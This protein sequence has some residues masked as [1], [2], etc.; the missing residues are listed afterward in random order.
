MFQYLVVT[1]TLM[2]KPRI[3]EE[4]LYQEFGVVGQR[5]RIWVKEE[6]KGT[7]IVYVGGAILELLSNREWI[8]VIDM[9]FTLRVSGYVK[10][11]G[12][13]LVWHTRGTRPFTHHGEIF[14]YESYK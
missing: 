1:G 13:S 8:I 14:L 4:G 10:D 11:R 6:R 7:E 9:E 3:G 12:S 2:T 5:T